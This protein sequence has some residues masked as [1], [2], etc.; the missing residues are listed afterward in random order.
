MATVIVPALLRPV[1][2]GATNVEV[3]GATVREVIADLVRQHEGL[4]DRVIDENGVRPEVFIAV[5]GQE[6]QDIEQA[7]PASAQVHILPAIAGG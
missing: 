4:R 2:D 5:D 6:V 1:A 3:T 7:V